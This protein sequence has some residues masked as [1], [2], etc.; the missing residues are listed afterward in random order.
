MS[1]VVG[2]I[3]LFGLPVFIL[4]AFAALFVA[5]SMTAPRPE[6]ADVVARPVAVF[7]SEAQP[8]AARL[9]VST[10]GE[11]RPVTQ[12]TLTS[13]VSGRIVR[14][15]PAFTEGG[16]FEAGE[17]LIEIDDADYRLAATRAEA[18]VAQARQRLLLEEAESELAREEWSSLG[19][20]DASTLA[21]REP[22]LAEARAQLAAANA[23]LQEARLNL[24]RT[25]ISAPFAGR[26]REKNADLGQYIGMGSQLGTVFST[27]AARIRLPLTDAQLGSLGIAVAFSETGAEPG[28]A[29]RLSAVVAGQPREWEGR[30]VRTDS[31][32]DP[33]TRTLFAIVEVQDPYGA[34]AEAA[35]APLPIGLFVEAQ[36]TGRALEN[37]YSLPR[38][39]LRGSD[40]ILVAGRDG[41]LSVRTVPVIDTSASRVIVASGLE[42]GEWVVTSPL[43]GAAEGMS[44]TPLGPDGEPL[45]IEREDPVV[46]GEDIDEADDE[47]RPVDAALVSAG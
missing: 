41:L 45:T 26:V 5:M 21:L 20:G 18:Q 6:R 34:A 19:Q 22:Q 2:R 46:S 43:R 36:I 31:A 47:D 8:D 7:V 24:E 39:A 9:T 30:V 15:N 23:S 37:V 27:D 16:F 40:Q 28:P 35:G 33:Q 11:V 4:L 32:I 38:S 14:V 17:T 10:Q 42:P 12:I 44:V 3:I 29:V 1:K 25:R 13:Q